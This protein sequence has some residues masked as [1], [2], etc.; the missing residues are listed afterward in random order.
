VIP[1][2]D[3]HEIRI[4]HRHRFPPPW[5]VTPTPSGFRVDDAMGRALAYV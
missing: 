4:D 2:C 5:T 1:F 3:A